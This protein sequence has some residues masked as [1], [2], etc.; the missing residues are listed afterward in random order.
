MAP[1]YR[2]RID[3]AAARPDL[4]MQLVDRPEIADFVIADDY[5]AREGNACRSSVAVKTVKLD[6]EARTPDVLVSISTDAPAADYKI[7]VHSVRY[8]HQDAAALLAVV[9]KDAQKRELAQR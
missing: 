3:N 5:A 9:W 7:Y 4:R 8:S 1:D 6:P 2:V